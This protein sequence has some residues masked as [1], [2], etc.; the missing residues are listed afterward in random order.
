M[1]SEPAAP[2]R[3]RRRSAETEAGDK[4]GKKKKKRPVVRPTKAK[5][6]VN[7]MV[8]SKDSALL[9]DTP[10]QKDATK[11]SNPATKSKD[12]P[13]KGDPSTVKEKPVEIPAATVEQL[14]SSTDSSTNSDGSLTSFE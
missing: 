1:D 4:S 5:E 7:P 13:D 9:L 2:T 14:N 6:I 12:Q 11:T 3:G 8:S 10:R